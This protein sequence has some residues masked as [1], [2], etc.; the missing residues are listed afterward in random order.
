MDYLKHIETKGTVEV[1]LDAAKSFENKARE[2]RHLAAQLKET[3]EWSIAGEAIQCCVDVFPSLRL[4]LLSIR[5]A[6]E[7][8]RKV[9][10]RQE[11]GN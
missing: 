6:R 5:P 7:L 3:G 8:E 10:A 9:Q 1:I 2:L 4:D 11:S